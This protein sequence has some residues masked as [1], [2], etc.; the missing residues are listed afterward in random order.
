MVIIVLELLTILRFNIEYTFKQ[1]SQ[2]RGSEAVWKVQ[3]RLGEE[4]PGAAA[5][6][7]I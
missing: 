2:I 3:V 4:D 5:E 6:T 1:L 7:K